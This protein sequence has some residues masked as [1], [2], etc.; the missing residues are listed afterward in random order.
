MDFA[1]KIGNQ[2]YSFVTQLAEK[3]VTLAPSQNVTQKN[4]PIATSLYRLQQ[5]MDILDNVAGRTPQLTRLE[6]VT[7][8]S[9][10]AVSAISPAILGINVVEVLVPSMAA[11]ASDVCLS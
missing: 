8:I 11:V 6:L 5:N 9:T 7:L 10:V 4:L 2:A 1:A 3:V